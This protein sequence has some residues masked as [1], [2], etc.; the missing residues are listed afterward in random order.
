MRTPSPRQ[1]LK[2]PLCAKIV[3]HRS[4]PVAFHNFALFWPALA[5]NFFEIFFKSREKEVFMPK[6]QK[7]LPAPKQTRTSPT[8]SRPVIT[9]YASL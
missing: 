1:A 3:P 2:P 5:I 4:R 9:D 8:S 7:P 6:P